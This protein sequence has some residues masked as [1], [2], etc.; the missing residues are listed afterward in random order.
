MV[1]TSKDWFLSLGEKYH[2]NP[3]IFGGI[4]V[5]LMPVEQI[6]ES[7]AI[8][9]RTFNIGHMMS[10]GGMGGTVMH[11]INGK[12]FDANRSDEVVNAGST[13]I[14]EFDN[15]AG[16]MGLKDDFEAVVTQLAQ[17][18]DVQG[19]RKE[20][21]KTE[22]MPFTSETK[23]MAT[24]NKNPKGLAVFAK[25]ATGELLKRCTQ[26]AFRPINTHNTNTFYL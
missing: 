25:D 23:I 4:Y 24:L 22:E 6:A 5:V 20:W 3:F 21:T 11:P 2:V 17:G 14:W 18:E 13:E 8:T 7:L 16:T 1:E 15:I 19:C 9:T 10:H 12:T 26:S